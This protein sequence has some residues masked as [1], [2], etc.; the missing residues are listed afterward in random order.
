MLELLQQY[1]GYAVGYPELTLV[2][3][4]YIQKQPIGRK[5][6]FVC[7]LPAYQAVLM[8]I[9]ILVVLVEYRIVPQPHRL[10]HLKIETY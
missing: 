8:I 9:K 4:Y 1:A 3:S 5:I 6:T 10:M 7:D 2:C